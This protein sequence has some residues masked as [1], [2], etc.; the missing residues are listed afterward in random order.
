MEDD[1]ENEEHKNLEETDDENTNRSVNMKTNK[2]KKKPGRPRTKPLKKSLKREGISEEPSNPDNCVEMVYDMPGILKKIFALFKAMSV[3]EIRLE[4]N[5][6]HINISTT[7]HLKRSNIKVTID[8]TKINRY[9]CAEPIDGYLNPS[10][11]EKIIQILNKDYLTIAFVLKTTTSRSI[12][13]IIYKNE[14][15]IDEYRE[16]NLIQSSNP[17]KVISFDNTNYPIKFVLPGKYFK[18]IIADAASFSDKLTIEKIGEG[19]LRFSYLSTDTK[20]KS[21][22]VVKDPEKIK[23]VST[24]AK[25]D[26]FSSSI[27]VDYIKPF[28]NA[29]LFPYVAISADTHKNMLFM[30]QIDNQTISIYISTD[31]VSLK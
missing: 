15:K 25:D 5:K 7:D 8:C 19:Y 24:V 1:N 22:Y 29:L 23:L 27:R 10:N 2:V 11:M 4:F 20:V 13:N 17:A 21:R 28:S 12:L 6:K 16:I 26:M 30:S 9:Y 31:I 14:M 18:K 3:K